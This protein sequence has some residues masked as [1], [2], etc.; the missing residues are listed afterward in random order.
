MKIRPR[1]NRKTLFTLIF[2][3]VL[4][5]TSK[6]IFQQTHT[7]TIFTAVQGDT[8]LFGNNEDSHYENLVIGVN[9][10]TANSFG[11][12]RFGSR[13]SDGSINFEGAVN[14][15]GLSWDV[16]SNPGT[17]LKPHPEKPYYLGTKNYL[18][19]LTNEVTSVEQAIQLAKTFSFG[20]V[21]KSQIHIADRTGDA[22][23]ISA[24][25]DGEIAF[26]RKNTAYGYLLS[27]NFNLAT[28]KGPVDFRW[29]TSS[30]MLDA[31]D[32]EMV[33]TPS[34]AG[35]ILEAVRLNNL[36]TYT[37]YSNVLDLKNNKVYLIYK[38]QFDEMVEIDM[39]EEFSKGER[40]VDMRD[41]FSSETVKAGDAAYQRFENRFAATKVGVVAVG[42]LLL[43]SVF[44]L[45]VRFI[46]KQKH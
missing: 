37:L 36:T 40:V 7:C 17:K 30:S 45:L 43:V 25:S 10:P 3:I 38:S 16:N 24:G 22:V 46:R 2:L 39:E 33:L 28:N 13:R 42:V 31:L 6:F 34:Y 8:V 11:S 41:F 26:T 9:P 21:M 4:P 29:E 5:I 20:D 32:S 44:I 19:T 27:T 12:I 1:I 14:N 18:T 35:E 15:Q 23:V